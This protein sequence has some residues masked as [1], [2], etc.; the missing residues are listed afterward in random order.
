[1]WASFHIQILVSHQHNWNY[2]P[3]GKNVPR[4]CKS[5]LKYRVNLK[6]YTSLR[7]HYL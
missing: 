1:L 4:K 2:F 7:R 5:D 3:Y 6:A